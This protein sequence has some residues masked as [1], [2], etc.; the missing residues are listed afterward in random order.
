MN[1]SLTI[2][3]ALVLVVLLLSVWG[4]IP[5]IRAW[6]ISQEERATADTE[7][8]A[9][10]EGIEEKA[11]RQG[12]D[13]QGGMYLVLE[14]DTEGMSGEQARDA[15]ERVREILANRVDQFGVSEPVIQTQGTSRI[16]VQLPGLQNPERAKQ[17]IGTTAQLEFRMLRSPEEIATALDKLDAAF[18]GAGADTVAAATAAADSVLAGDVARDNTEVAVEAGEVDTVTT[19]FGELPDA[20]EEE[21]AD[22]DEEMRRDRPFSSYMLADPQLGLL[23]NERHVNRVQQ[24]LDSPRARVLPRDVT[25]QFSMETLRAPDGSELRPLYLVDATPA[26]TGDRLTG[27]QAVPDPERP[28]NFQVSFTLDRRGGAR[29]ARL[30]GENVGRRMAIALDNRVKSAPVI[31]DRIPGGRGVITGGFSLEAAQDLALLLRAGALPTDVHIEEE[32]TVG[33]SLGRDS[34]RRGI[35]AVVYGGILV[36][37]FVIFYYRVSGLISVVALV[38]N[39]IILL[40]VLAQ[41]GLVLT[42]PGIA[43]IILTVGMAV[44]ANVL[45]NER[46]REECA[47][48]R[49]SRRRWRAATATPRARSSTRTSRR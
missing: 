5:T 12:L 34:I 42:L 9:E 4:L 48:T 41:F 18:R 40:A 44:D 24:M 14:V 22:L 25:F 26:L 10:I 27:A 1:R 46:I 31:Q 28:G 7:R 39:I 19:P 13:L 43:G 36:I 33:P 20:V 21:F 11:I 23:V 8:L 32:R 37:V 47:G 35:S 16:I 3:G 49:R 29:F 38:S 45:I 2:R 15:L 6:S 30:T 17:L